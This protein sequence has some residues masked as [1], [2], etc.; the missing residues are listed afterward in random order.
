MAWLM[1]LADSFGSWLKMTN[2]LQVI[3]S[4]N[5]CSL[6]SHEIW[7]KEN[8]SVFNVVFLCRAHC[9]TKSSSLQSPTSA[10]VLMCFSASEPPHRRPMD[11]YFLFSFMND[12]ALLQHTVTHGYREVL[13]RLHMAG[14]TLKPHP[15]SLTLAKAPH[16]H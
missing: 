11:F 12:G 2:Y 6:Q 9:G 1:S 7:I 15:A 14:G 8:A 3:L 10:L 4:L 13:C 5:A 16:G